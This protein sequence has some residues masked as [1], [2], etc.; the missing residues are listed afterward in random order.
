MQ[1]IIYYKSKNHKL[2][3]V[4]GHGI[5]KRFPLHRHKSVS[6]GMVLKG[7][8]LLTIHK[9]KYII[10]EGDIFIIN[11]EEPHSI[12]ETKNPEHNYIV[13]SL[14]PQL[15][16]ESLN[17]DKFYFR[18]IIQNDKLSDHLSFLFE[19]L[20]K[21]NKTDRLVDLKIILENICENI[22][23]IRHEPTDNR[24]VKAKNIMDTMLSEKLSL[25]NIADKAAL[26]IFHFSRLFKKNI[27]MAPHQYL[28]DNRLRC[29]REL[30]EKGH[31]I[32]DVAIAAGFYDSS[33]FIRHFMKYYGVSPLEYQKG[34]NPLM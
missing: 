14:S 9:K 24:L 6:L 1:S 8:R 27:G 17:T 12:G 2:S 25:N 7:S 34:I 32:A 4:C 16:A 3:I 19:E 11:S 23:E 15:L 26:S 30:L 29:A 33:H 5:S 28:L 18:N 10:A 21:K 20:M 31:N 13:L 22:I